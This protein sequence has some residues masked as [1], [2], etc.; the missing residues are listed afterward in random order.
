MSVNPL[1]HPP[2]DPNTGLDVFLIAY[3][4]IF[5]LNPL[6]EAFRGQGFIIRLVVYDCVCVRGPSEFHLKEASTLMRR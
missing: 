1:L 6:S 2:D 3:G 4:F 5:K